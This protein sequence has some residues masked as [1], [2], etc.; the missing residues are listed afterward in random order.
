MKSL[1]A[2]ALACSMSAHAEFKDGNKLYSELNSSNEIE[3]GISLGYIMGM[4]DAYQGILFC[5]AANVTAGQIRDM[6]KQYLSASPAIRD[7]AANELLIGLFSTVW[8]CK[9]K[10]T[11]L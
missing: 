4:A 9:K 11:A 5:P 10:G 6:T 1:V 8:P 7:K 2:L 3:W